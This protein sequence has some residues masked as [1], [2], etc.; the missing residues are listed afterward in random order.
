MAFSKT[1]LGRIHDVMA[2]HVERGGVPGL[3]TLVSRGD[4]VHVDAIGLSR[5][6]PRGCSAG[7]FESCARRS[8]AAFSKVQRSPSAETARL[9]CVRAV[10]RG[11]PSHARR[12]TAQRQFH[13]GNPPPAAAPST[14]AVR[15]P[16]RPSGGARAGTQEV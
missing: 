16:I 5:N 9:A 11:S 12:H 2:H 14:M 4:E 15:R 10:T 8:G 7:V 6:A 3:V 1:R 13:C